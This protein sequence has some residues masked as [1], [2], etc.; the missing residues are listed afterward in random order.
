MLAEDDVSVLDL[1]SRFM[2]HVAEPSFRGFERAPEFKRIYE[3]LVGVQSETGHFNA[4]KVITT[5]KRSPED[6]GDGAL[7][8]TFLVP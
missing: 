5:F 6:Q 8:A 2:G 7:H 3:V 1:A 4:S